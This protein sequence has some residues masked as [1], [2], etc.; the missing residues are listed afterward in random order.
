M[1]AFFTKISSILLALLVLCSTFSFTVEKHFCGEFL[2]DVSYFGDTDYCGDEIGV[3]SCD[4]GSKI[5]KKKCCKDEVEQIEGQDDL[6]MSSVEKITFEQ[7]F[8]VLFAITYHNLFVSPTN[9][10]SYKEY[11]P[12]KLVTDI[13]VLHEVF[14]I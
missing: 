10:N 1:K 2:V 5:T 9:N 12:P 4:T 11:S 7:Q 3:N 13:Q 8:A 6:K 14:I